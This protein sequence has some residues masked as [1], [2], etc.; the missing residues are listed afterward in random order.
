MTGTILRSVSV[1]A[2]S[3]V[4]LGGALAANA[5]TPAS[6]PMTATTATT[7]TRPASAPSASPRTGPSYYTFMKECGDDHVTNRPRRFTLAC[8][9]AKQYLDRMTWKRWGQ[10]AATGTGVV[11]LRDCSTSCSVGRLKSYPVKV[12]VNRIHRGEAAQFYTRMTLTYTKAV[13]AGEKRTEVFH[14]PR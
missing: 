12:V 13:P 8:A 14:L 3:A 11:R 5:A 2:L 1:A 6:T 7:A 9:D 10:S 4:A